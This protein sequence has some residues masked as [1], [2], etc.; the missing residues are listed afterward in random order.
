MQENSIKEQIDTKRITRQL[1][2]LLDTPRYT[3]EIIALQCDGTS[4]RA[5]ESVGDLAA[6]LVGRDGDEEEVGPVGV[7]G[8]KAA[9][10]DVLEEVSLAG[11]LAGELPRRL[12]EGLGVAVRVD[13][14]LEA[15][16][17]IRVPRRERFG[18]VVHGR[19]RRR[20]RGRG[21]GGREAAGFID[22][23]GGGRGG[24]ERPEGEEGYREEGCYSEE[25]ERPGEGRR[26]AG[27]AAGH[28]RRWGEEWSEGVIQGADWKGTTTPGCFL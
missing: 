2:S 27:E 21:G 1:E 26:G 15:P 4:G 9:L 10:P 8:A 18:G 22:G 7:F 28:R 5:K 19:A 20:Q 23:E 13:V 12:V 24:A 17:H 6:H 14:H 3:K 25:E 16:L 11:V